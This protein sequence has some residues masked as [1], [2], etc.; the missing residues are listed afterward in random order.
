MVTG[1]SAHYGT[2]EVGK[3]ADFLVLNSNPLTDIRNLADIHNIIR[4]GIQFS[5]DELATKVHMK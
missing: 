3:K 1:Q 4:H 5:Q 2:V